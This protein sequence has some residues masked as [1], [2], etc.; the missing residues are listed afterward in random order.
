MPGRLP[1]QHPPFRLRSALQDFASLF[2]SF[3]RFFGRDSLQSNS[4]PTDP[5]TDIEPVIDPPDRPPASPG[6][7]ME[8]AYQPAP[9]VVPADRSCQLFSIQRRKFVQLSPFPDTS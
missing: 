4:L 9:T 1:C 5:T 6:E 7:G 8:F 2:R 3:T